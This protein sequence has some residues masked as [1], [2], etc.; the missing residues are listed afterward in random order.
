M[1]A[2]AFQSVADRPVL[3]PESFRGGC[4]FG[5][6]GFPPIS[7]GGQ[8]PRNVRDRDA[9]FIPAMQRL[10]RRR[11]KFNAASR[12]FF[13]VLPAGWSSKPI[14]ISTSCSVGPEATG[15]FTTRAKSVASS[16]AVTLTSIFCSSE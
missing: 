15:T 6:G 13:L 12:Y 5:A 8:Y 9:T 14:W 3:L 16:G 4:S 7:P 10:R 1:C 11:A 2:R